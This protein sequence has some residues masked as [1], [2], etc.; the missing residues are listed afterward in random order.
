MLLVVGA[1]GSGPPSPVEQS[2]PTEAAPMVT[3]LT[4]TAPERASTEGPGDIAQATAPEITE[5]TVADD[6]IVFHVAKPH[7]SEAIES[8]QVR[9]DEGRWRALDASEWRM[10]EGEAGIVV[11]LRGLE[12]TPGQPRLVQLR[13]VNIAGV[14]PASRVS[15]LDTDAAVDNPDLD[16]T[17]WVDIDSAMGLDGSAGTRTPT[18]PARQVI[19]IVVEVLAALGLVFVGILI[20]R[21]LRRT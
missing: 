8:Y 4:S 5:A 11:T 10:A 14:G 19:V 1:C 13:A 15:W 3:V 18:D 12:L 21:R 9:L 16:S 20:G 17:D 7:V 6:A 2:T